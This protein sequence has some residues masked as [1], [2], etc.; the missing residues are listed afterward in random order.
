MVLDFSNRFIYFNNIPGFLTSI[1]VHAKS[2]PKIK[3]VIKAV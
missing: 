2:R 3:R 1:E